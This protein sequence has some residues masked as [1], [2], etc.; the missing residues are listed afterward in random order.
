MKIKQ[1]CPETDAFCSIQNGNMYLVIRKDYEKILREMGIANPLEMV[2]QQGTNID[3]YRGRGMHA[4]IDV[5]HHE[6]VRIV[7][8]HCIRG[9]PVKYFT[10][11]VFIGQARPLQELCLS[12][13]AR[14]NNVNTTEI[15]AVHVSRFFGIFY[16][17]DIIS[18]EIPDSFNLF[19][20]FTGLGEN[21]P[22]YELM[23]K[24]RMIKIIARLIK[25]MHEAGIYHHDLNIKNILVQ[26]KRVHDDNHDV[27]AFVIDLDRAQVLKKINLRLRMKNLLRLHRSLVKLGLCGKI[28]T[29][30]D[31]LRFLREYMDSEDVDFT[32][33]SSYVKRYRV[34]L[35]FHR[36]W[37]M[38][39]GNSGH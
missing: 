9:G 6:G 36:W 26:R 12:D 7:V 2:R 32:R 24:R 17:G 30:T 13:F 33:I 25:S 38:L 15:V 27:S 39:T 10:K 34:L 14:R 18:L 3:F 20:Y 11:D 37:W 28:I 31:I 1:I 4:V 8:K 16:R 22:Q 19:T 21:V 29:K 23:E 5:P 35:K